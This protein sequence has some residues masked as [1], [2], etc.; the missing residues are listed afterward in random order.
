MHTLPRLTTPRIDIDL[1]HLSPAVDKLH[2]VVNI[3]TS[4]GTFSNVSNAYVRMCAVKNGH[5]L[6]R[7]KLDGNCQTNGLLFATLHRGPLG[8]WQLE[9]KGTEV[10]GRTATQASCLAGCKVEGN[11]DFKPGMDESDECCTLM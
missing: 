1:D 4:G 11:S 7:Y 10:S 2:I 6:C 5:E 9:A 8:N 3:Y